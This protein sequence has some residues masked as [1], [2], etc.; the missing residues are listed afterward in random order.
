MAAVC[1]GSPVPFLT[2]ENQ[3]TVTVRVWLFGKYLLKNV[4]CSVEV[5]GTERLAENFP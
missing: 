4:C 3:R 1:A 2:L 5:P